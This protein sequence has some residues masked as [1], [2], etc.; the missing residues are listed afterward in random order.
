[1]FYLFFF[2]EKNIEKSLK[3]CFWLIEN[4]YQVELYRYQYIFLNET[5]YLFFFF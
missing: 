5:I 1:M 2:I 3:I 4:I